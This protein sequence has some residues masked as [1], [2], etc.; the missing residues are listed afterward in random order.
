MTHNVM[1]TKSQHA[2]AFVSTK[3]AQTSAPTCV[4]TSQPAVGRHN[5]MLITIAILASLLKPLSLLSL[6]CWATD[7]L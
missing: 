5:T 3:Q 7:T 1:H 6:L 4:A 2:N